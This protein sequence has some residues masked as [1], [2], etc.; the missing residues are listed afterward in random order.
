MSLSADHPSHNWALGADGKLHRR[1]PAA[2]AAQRERELQQEREREE[3]QLQEDEEE[4]EEE[5]EE[6]EVQP[7]LQRRRRVDRSPSA[8]PASRPSAEAGSRSKLYLLLAAVLLGLIVLAA[9]HDERAP[10]EPPVLPWQQ[11]RDCSECSRWQR[12]QT[13]DTGRVKCLA[14]DA[15]AEQCACE[16]AGC[17]RCPDGLVLEADRCI[18]IDECAVFGRVP[19]GGCHVATAC[20]NRFGS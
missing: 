2:V 12:C 13:T 6:L 9:L 3:Q 14:C 19:G 7:Q 15:P 17:G 18:D 4:E 1:K 5:E 8:S 20:A 16:G 10:G 11:I